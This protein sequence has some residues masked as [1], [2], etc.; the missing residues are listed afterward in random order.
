M[1]RSTQ[2]TADEPDIEISVGD[3]PD[4]GA[5][6]TA[7]LDAADTMVVVADRD[8]TIVYVN[9]AFTA[10]TGYSREEAIGS[11]CRLLRSGVQDDAFYAEMW[12]TIL[13][14]RTWH[15]EL[16][17]RR[18]D[19]TLYADE[20]T[21][22]PVGPEPARHFVAIKRDLSTR[23]QP[24]T[25]ASPVGIAHAERDGRLMY[26]NGRAEVM[27]GGSFDELV[28]LRWVERLEPQRVGALL[29][30]IEAAF[31][32]D[33]AA[34]P[35]ERRVRLRSGQWLEIHGA[36]LVGDDGSRLGVVLAFDDVTAEMVTA[37]ALDERERFTRAILD[38]LSDATAVVDGRG[39]V[40]AVNT[41]WERFAH[42][43]GGDLEACGVGSDYLGVCARSAGAGCDD[44]AVIRD[45]LTEV[46]SGERVFFEFEYA[47]PS[48]T[49]PRWY[50]QRITPLEGFEGAVLSHVDIT[51]RKQAELRLAEAV[52]H[53]P[54]TGVLNRNAIH[55][56][57]G[58]IQAVLFVDLDGFKEV[59]DTLGHAA[60]DVV[61]ARAADRIRHQTRGGDQV[62]RVGGDEFVVILSP[63]PNI[64]VDAVA[65]RIEEALSTPYQVGG[66]VATIGASVGIAVAR[67]GETIGTLISRADEAMYRV[68]RSHYSSRKLGA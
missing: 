1:L 61:L 59:N 38:S 31:A 43:N 36:P 67:S 29:A 23:T 3:V 57:R 24:L 35:T 8:A 7:L 9:P 66:Q 51:W 11:S 5:V 32:A 20:M 18:K 45:A 30:D 64:D 33:P 48:R 4:P 26:V 54:L 55:E 6:A 14:G 58:A 28:G 42:L 62:A 60:G 40:V 52:S 47:C 65:E 49:E 41:A 37:L 34:A 27:L 12:Q 13:A 56:A 50:L 21:I 53:D 22:V 25:A 39:M 2:D 68:K 10:V 44:A 15:G 63:D 17:N 16:I 19:G 46:L